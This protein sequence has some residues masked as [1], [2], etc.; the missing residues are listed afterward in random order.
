MNHQLAYGF[1][2][3]LCFASILALCELLHKKGMPAEHTRKIAHSLS[4][5]LC[6]VVPVFF[7]S[8]VYALVFVAGALAILCAGKRGGFLRSIHSVERWTCGAYLLPVSICFAYYVSIWTRDNMCFVLPV[9]VLAISDP[10]ACWFGKSFKS[11]ILLFN[12]TVAGTLAFFV[13]SWV[14][15]S[16]LFWSRSTCFQALG[17]AFAMSATLSAVE[18]L[19]PKGTD[20]LTIPVSAILMLRMVLPFVA[21]GHPDGGISIP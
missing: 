5:L 2:F 13:S 9:L 4:T 10:L 12:K 8:R 17:M 1:L 15:C 14:L 3:M 21:G 19:S 18:L 20:N 6:L 16:T 7:S 11:K